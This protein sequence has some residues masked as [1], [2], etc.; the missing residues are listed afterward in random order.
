MVEGLKDN[1]REKNTREKAI[2]K[3]LR[4]AY[5]HVYVVEKLNTIGIVSDE[6][7]EDINFYV[8]QEI[9]SLIRKLAILKNDKTI[10]DDSI[11]VI[12]SIGNVSPSKTLK[13][14]QQIYEEEKENVDSSWSKA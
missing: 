1:I 11:L 14:V 10:I 13:L 4:S 2:I 3:D 5:R 9:N 12:W 7:K 6:D 8:E